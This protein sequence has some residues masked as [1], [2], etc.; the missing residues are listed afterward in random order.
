[1]IEEEKRLEIVQKQLKDLEGPM[2]T[3]VSIIRSQIEHCDKEL[4]IEGREL[5]ALEKAY[6]DKQ[7]SYARKLL[8]YF[9]L[10]L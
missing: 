1:M 9:F 3:D 6:F 7:K 8:V 5:E 10:F 2:R 4:S